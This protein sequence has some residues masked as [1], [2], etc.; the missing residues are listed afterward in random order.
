MLLPYD[1]VS[2]C[3]VKWVTAL[4]C[5]MLDR[6]CL[7]YSFLN[8]QTKMIRD[9]IKDT[10]KLL[11]SKGYFT[12]HW[13]T[14]INGKVHFCQISMLPLLAPVV[15][16]HLFSANMFSHHSLGQGISDKWHIL[17]WWLLP[18]IGALGGVWISL[19]VDIYQTDMRRSKCSSNPLDNNLLTDLTTFYILFF[20]KKKFCWK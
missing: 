3:H 17:I 18:L 4:I 20:I 5:K 14:L 10:F 9:L 12:L 16:R 8:D 15:S 6:C 13:Q 1:R 19:T 11:H 2:S 7:Q